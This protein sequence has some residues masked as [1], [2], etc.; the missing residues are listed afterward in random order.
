MKFC[1]E[2]FAAVVFPLGASCYY[3]PLTGSASIHAPTNRNDV[4]PIYKNSTYCVDDRVEDLIKRMTIE[5]KAGQ[6]FKP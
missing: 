3:E 6:L 5:E 2:H 1:F 4:L